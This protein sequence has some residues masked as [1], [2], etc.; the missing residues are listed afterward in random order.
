MFLLKLNLAFNPLLHKLKEFY[1]HI[2]LI[3]SFEMLEIKEKKTL[4]EN[5]IHDFIYQYNSCLII[6]EKISKSDKNIKSLKTIIL[7][8]KKNLLKKISY[9]ECS[10]HY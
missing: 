6:K 9:Y 5:V 2:V 7:K 4:M 1:L 8:M 10:N 3:H